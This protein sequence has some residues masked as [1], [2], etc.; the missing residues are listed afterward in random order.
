MAW[1][2]SVTG[3]WHL[4]AADDSGSH[5]LQ[6]IS[7]GRCGDPPNQ[8]DWFPDGHRMAIEGGDV[9]GNDRL[10]VEGIGAGPT[11][12]LGQLAEK[13]EDPMSDLHG[14][15]GWPVVSPDGSRIASGDF[16]SDFA[17]KRHVTTLRVYDVASGRIT[18]AATGVE[19]LDIDATGRATW[20]ATL[21]GTPVWVTGAAWSP[22]SRRLL[23]LSPEPDD[24]SGSW[25]IRAVDAA[26]AGPSSVVASKVRSF[27]LGYP[28]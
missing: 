13:P 16:M 4:V 6:Q 22:D 14:K 5:D 3:Q 27:D 19:Q 9:M 8:I 23:Y 1:D 2:R 15:F 11:D 17:A 26:G 10:C 20:G 24:S 21:E 18:D 28:H 25:T 12:R 7:A